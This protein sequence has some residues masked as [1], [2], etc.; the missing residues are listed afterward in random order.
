MGAS[1]GFFFVCNLAIQNKAQ[2]RTLD[3]KKELIDK[4]LFR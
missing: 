3:T 1:S 4:L 2:P